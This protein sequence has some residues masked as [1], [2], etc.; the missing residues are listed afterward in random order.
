VESK[1]DKQ[2]LRTRRLLA[3]LCVECGSDKLGI[4]G[5]GREWQGC[6]EHGGYVMTAEKV[7]CKV[8]GHEEEV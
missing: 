1:E 6:R 8:C 4:V 3:G 7:I 5:A 2:K